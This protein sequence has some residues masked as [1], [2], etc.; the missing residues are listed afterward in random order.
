MAD[1]LNVKKL[2]VTSHNRVFY[3]NIE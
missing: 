1:Y 2:P 3:L